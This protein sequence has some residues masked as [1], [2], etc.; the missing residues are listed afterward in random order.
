[1][2]AKATAP[3]GCVYVGAVAQTCGLLRCVL[4]RPP[5]WPEPGGWGVS[6]V[7]ALRRYSP[8][9][10]ILLAPVRLSFVFLS[11]R[12]GLLGSVSI[13]LLRAPSGAKRLFVRDLSIEGLSTSFF[14]INNNK[15]SILLTTSVE[16]KASRLRSRKRHVRS[17]SL[18]F[19]VGEIVVCVSRRPY[20]LGSIKCASI[21]PKACWHRHSLRHN[22]VLTSLLHLVDPLASIR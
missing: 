6:H 8:L 5:N 1:M 10:V 14:F 12:K 22:V 16:D 4:S 9:V 11:Y 17:V 15:A 21:H 20:N 19:V 2:A 18:L 7:R 3:S 13:S